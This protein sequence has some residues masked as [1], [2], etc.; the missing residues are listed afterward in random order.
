MKKLLLL[1]G[2]YALTALGQANQ[3]VVVQPDC[4]V[5]FTFTATGSRQFDNRAGSC[6]TW[7]V[8]YYSTGF[9]A[10]SLVLETAPDNNGVP[11][12]WS[13]FTAATGSNPN[14][15]T[16]SAQ[17]TFGTTTS[18]YPWVRIRLASVTGTGTIRGAF[19]A[20]KLSAKSASG[21]GGGGISQAYQTI[22]QA[23]VALTQRFTLNFVSGTSCVD[24]AGTLTTDCTITGA[25]QTPN[26]QQ[27]FTSATSVALTHNLNTTATLTQC[28]DGSSN[29]EVIPNTTT[30]T[31][32]NVVT[33][34]FSVAQ[35][36]YC[37]VNGLGGSGGGPTVHH[38]YFPAAVVTTVTC[39]AHTDLLSTT[40]GPAATNLCG[41]NPLGI[42]GPFGASGV[43]QV[44]L[45]IPSTWN[46]SA[47]TITLD[48]TTS[49][50]G[51]G[52]FSFTPSYACVANGT[53]V[54]SALSFTTG[55]TTT[56]AAPGGSGSGFYREP[57]TM[58]FTPTC[59]AS[60][61]IQIQYTRG[62]SDTYAGNIYLIG[63]DVAI[64]Y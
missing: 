28:Y 61:S 2:S 51:T 14:T 62:A 20:Y 42:Q 32:V 41:S 22:E 33:V 7:V 10:L 36:G 31:S 58:T 40:S 46:G 4:I 39:G 15:T 64:T 13:T 57:V 6:S 47:I 3:S 11:G 1:L 55:S 37:N 21:S 60:N 8:N 56:V 17:S 5:A 29:A 59:V 26:Y 38:Q 53:D 34:T 48:A 35:T 50:N 19:F 54:S 44:F 30:I 9:S 16:T 43:G 12:S 49:T 24:N 18:F 63:V 27:S 25:A 52:N 23:G 45:Y